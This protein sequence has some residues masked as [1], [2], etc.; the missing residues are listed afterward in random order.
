MNRFFG[1]GRSIHHGVAIAP[2]KGT[3]IVKIAVAA[4]EIQGLVTTLIE[5]T[6]E[7]EQVFIVRPLHYRVT[8]RRGDRQGN[9]LQAAHGAQACGVKLGEKQAVLGQAVKIGGQALFVA[10]GRHEFRGQTFHRNQHHVQVLFRTVADHLT[11]DGHTCIGHKIGGTTPA[12]LGAQGFEH[13]RDRQ[14][15]I[16]RCVVDFVIAK[17]AEEF[18]MPVAC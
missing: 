16:K 17:G 5:N 6:A 10:K 9:R 13:I 4:V 3:H 12:K 11:L 18:V 2:E 14:R 8:R 1:N 7:R 15:T